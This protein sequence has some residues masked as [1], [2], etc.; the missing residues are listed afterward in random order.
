VN[1]HLEKVNEQLLGIPELAGGF[2]GL[3]FSQGDHYERSELM[4]AYPSSLQ[5]VNSSEVRFPSVHSAEHNLNSFS[6]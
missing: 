2:D 5:A 4:V 6:L 1:E 3:G